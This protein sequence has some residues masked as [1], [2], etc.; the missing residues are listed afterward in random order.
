MPYS[1][2]TKKTVLISFFVLLIGIAIGIVELSDGSFSASWGLTSM[3]V[4]YIAF[5][6]CFLSWI[7]MMIGVLVRGV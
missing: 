7:I 6:L 4:M 3:Q 1:P 2:P 5:G